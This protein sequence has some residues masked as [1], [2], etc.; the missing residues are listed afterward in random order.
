MS[1]TS[2]LT[3]EIELEIV[4]AYK[5]NAK[6]KE[7]EEMFGICNQSI[8][9]VLRRQGVGINN[10]NRS[11]GVKRR[12]KRYCDCGAVMPPEAKFCHM[13]GKSLKTDEEI[14]IDNLLNARAKCLAQC[15]AGIRSDVDNAIMAAVKLL[16]E[17]C[18]VK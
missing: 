13:C 12:K 18:G 16:K 15:T 5:G 11:S 7:I 4:E 8:Y 14:I 3:P 10:P 17:K 1:R 6:I 9:G 2:K